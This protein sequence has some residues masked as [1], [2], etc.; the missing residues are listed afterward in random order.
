MWMLMRRCAV[1]VAGAAVGLTAAAAPVYRA[2][3]VS[4]A[5]ALDGDLSDA[6]WKGAAWS[7]GF[8]NRDGSTPQRGTRFKAV[9]AS[10]AVYV[11]VECAESTPEK[12]A[13]E[14][15][16]H[17]FW[18]CDVVEV[19]SCAAK[20]ETLHLV[21]SARG[22]LNDEIDGKTV[23]RTKGNIGWQAKSKIA[24]DRWTC[25]FRIPFLLFGVVPAD[26]EIAAPFNVCRNATSVKELS[27]WSQAPNFKSKADYGT[28]VL[29]K[30]PDGLA[31]GL[32]RLVDASLIPESAETRARREDAE[33]IMKR[34]F[35]E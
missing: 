22:N 28:L 24:A 23:A 19:F 20:N 32:R 16:A 31:E 9:Y 11:A 29:A 10:D 25:E 5:P 21:C 33:R 18:L 30:S 6:C 7:S 2:E 17:E 1:A 15:Q 27:C 12:M 34:L 35:D 4:A 3:Y 13:D 14:H 8:V 26:G